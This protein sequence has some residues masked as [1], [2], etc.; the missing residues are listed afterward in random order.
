MAGTVAHVVGARPN[1]MKALAGHPRP[2]ARRAS[3][4]GSSTPASTTTRRCPTCSSAI[5]ALPEPDLNLGVGSGTQ[6][7]Q[8]AALMVAL[9]GAFDAVEPALAVV[10]GDVN[11][12]V[13]A[14]LVAAKTLLPLAHVEAG[15]RSF[16]DTMPEEINRRVTDLLSDL[17]FVT[18]PEGIDQPRPDGRR[19]RADPLRRQPDDRHAARE[20]RP[21][22]PGGRPRHA[23]GLPDALRGRDAAPARQRRRR[24][25]GRARRCDAARRR[26]PGA[27]R[28]SA[29]SARPGRPRAGGSRRPTTGS[30]SSSR[31][32]TSTSCRSSEA[33]P[34]WSP[35]RAASRRRRRSSACRA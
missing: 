18:S 35:T 24:R 6:A 23:L 10:Y 7:A 3:S 32:A 8:T 34:S 20:P 26:G 33:P 13:A 30:G 14:A 5:S 21:L 15:L 22:R 27:A 25:T 19:R 31:S 9:E 12:T 4:S 16:D 17:L 28:P 2:R 1:F 11:S 29:P